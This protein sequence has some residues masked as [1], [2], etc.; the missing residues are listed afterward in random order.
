MEPV[1]RVTRHL[2]APSIGLN[3]SAPLEAEETYS[4]WTLEQA[5]AWHQQTGW[6]VG[7]NFIPSTA[8]NQLEM[9]QEESFDSTTINREISWAQKLGFNTARVYLHH[10]LWVQNRQG[11][12]E[13]V[14]KFLKLADRH[15]IGVIF[16]I[17]DGVWD[18]HPQLGPQSAPKPGVHNSGWLQS[19]GVEI[20]SNPSRHDELEDYI[21]GTIHHFRDDRRVLLWDIFNEPDNINQPAYAGKETDRKAEYALQVLKKAFGWARA[22]QPVQPLTAGVWIGHWSDPQKLSPIEEYCLGNSDVISFHNYGTLSDIKK[23]V[24]SLRRYHRPM[25]CT[26]YMSRGSGSTFD[27]ILGYLRDQNIGAINWGLVAG[28]TQTI[29]PWD[30]WAKTYAT[31]PARWFHDILRPDGTPYENREVE[32]IKSITSCI[33]RGSEAHLS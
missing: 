4:P 20:L 3:P 11:Y 14:D 1:K 16:V 25:L 8:I 6:R 32:Y 26:E 12:L 28:K 10:L 13:R 9:W 30:S 17:L 23:C 31:E 33:S 7:C 24:R 2:A 27:P 29:Y 19:P 15:Q 21:Y 5:N 18:P 22:A